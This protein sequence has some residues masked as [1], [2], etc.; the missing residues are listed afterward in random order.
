M[1]ASGQE[2]REDQLSIVITVPIVSIGTV[3][4]GLHSIDLRSF[5]GG[6]FQTPRVEAWATQQLT[7][8]LG[9]C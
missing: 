6:G 5:Q 8:M 9:A 2:D 1:H 4:S 3:R 7:S